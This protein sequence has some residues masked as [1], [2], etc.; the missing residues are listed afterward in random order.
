MCQL[1]VSFQAVHQAFVC[2]VWLV[3]NQK[4]HLALLWSMEVA[5][6]QTPTVQILWGKQEV[7]SVCQWAV[8]A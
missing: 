1:V 5:V 4:A 6:F 8:P 3:A 2:L 7:A